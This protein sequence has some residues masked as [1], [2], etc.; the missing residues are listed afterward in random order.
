VGLH[1]FRR[2]GQG[3]QAR[4]RGRPRRDARHVCQRRPVEPQEDGFRGRPHPPARARRL[5]WHDRAAAS[6]V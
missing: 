3:H 5:R 6:A 4:T 1:R 2:S